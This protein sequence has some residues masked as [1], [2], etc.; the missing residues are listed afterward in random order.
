MKVQQS[1]KGLI[2]CWMTVVLLGFGSTGCK[3]KTEEPPV[4]PPVPAAPTAQPVKQTPPPKPAPPRA[5]NPGPTIKLKDVLAAAK[6]WKPKTLNF[7]GPVPDLSLTDLQGATHKLSSLRGKNVL[8]NFWASWSPHYKI[9]L[10]RLAQ[11]REEVPAE[12]LAIL[13]ITLIDG[14]NPQ[15]AVMAAVKGQSSLNYPVIATT[16][17][18]LPAP[19]TEVEFL[20]SCFFI[21]AKGEVKVVTEGLV[22]QA[23]LQSLVRAQ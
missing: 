13:A 5:V 2:A 21:N 8:V 4:T 11:L 7:K 9:M 12:E 19:F 14:Q 6:S 20:P 15:S 3:K 18:A 1:L 17:A 10:P 23:D 22:S 16:K